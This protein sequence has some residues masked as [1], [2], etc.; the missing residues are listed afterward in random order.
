MTAML[1]S[2]KDASPASTAAASWEPYQLESPVPARKEKIPLSEKLDR[3]FIP[4]AIVEQQIGWPLKTFE[5]S[6]QHAILMEYFT[7]LM[8]QKS[9]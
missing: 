8:L 2:R 6:I 7:K 1:S 5:D 9:F 3:V 4:A